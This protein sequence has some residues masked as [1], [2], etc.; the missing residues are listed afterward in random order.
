MPFLKGNPESGNHGCYFT[1][2]HYIQGIS[3]NRAANNGLVPYMVPFNN[4][5]GKGDFSYVPVVS[6]CTIDMSFHHYRDDIPGILLSSHKGLSLQSP[7]GT[8]E[9]GSVLR[10]SLGRFTACP[11][12]KDLPNISRISPYWLCTICTAQE[13]LLVNS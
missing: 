4:W 5:N 6:I 2:P 7:Q 3:E 12:P 9:L 8:T 1:C 11:L 13:W 10:M